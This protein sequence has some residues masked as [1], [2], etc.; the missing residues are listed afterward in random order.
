MLNNDIKSK[1][2]LLDKVKKSKPGAPGPRPPM[3]APE[4]DVKH[5]SVAQFLDLKDEIAAKDQTIDQLN[6]QIIVLDHQLQNLK[7]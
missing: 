3:Q 4:S 6:D 1:S 2:T 5:E 7:D